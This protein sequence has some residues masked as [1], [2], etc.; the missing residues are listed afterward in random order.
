M[1]AAAMPEPER[2]PVVQVTSERDTHPSFDLTRW[3][4]MQGAEFPHL[5]DVDFSEAR[6]DER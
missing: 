4:E 2:T 3:R 1:T 5:L 6:H